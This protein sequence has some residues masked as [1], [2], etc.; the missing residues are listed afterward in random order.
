MKRSYV[1]LGFCIWVMFIAK[2]QIVTTNPAFPIE[3]KAVTLIFDAAQGTA[4]LKGYTGD[5]YAHT[6]VI[7]DQS[8]KESDWRYASDWN[9]NVAKYKMTSLGNNK[10]EL[11]IT[12]DVRSYY[13]VPA[14]EKILKMAFVFRSSDGK[15]EGKD[16]GGKDI[17][18]DIHETGLTVRFDQPSGIA[19]L[20]SGET[21]AMKASASMVADM[22]LFVGNEP[23]ATQSN[24]KEIIAEHTFL[25]AGNFEIRVEATIGGQTET[26]TRTVNVLGE[27]VQAPLPANVRPGINYLS[28]HEATLVLQ[29]PKKKTVHVVGDFNDW[30][31]SPE[32]QLKQDG[33]F[34]WITLSGLE[35]EKEYAFQYVVDG[36]IYIADP[37]A[38]KVLDPWND[39]YIPSTVYPDLKPYP[40]GKAEG[41]VSVLQTGQTPYQWQVTDFKKPDRNQLMVYEM[42]IRD[43]TSEH[44]FNAAKDKLPYLKQLGINAIELMPVNE[45][46][47]NSSW[48]Y[49][50]SFYFAVDKYYGTKNDMRAFVDECHQQG[51]AVIIDLV[52]NHSFGQSPFYLLYR[53]ADGT[54]SADNPWYNQK[55]NIPNAAL[56]WGYDFN[57][58]S[59]YTRALVD[60]VAGFWM[61]EYK[62]DGFRYDFTKG[63][64]N[65]SQDTWANKYDAE[66]IANL[67]RMS[68]EIWKRNSD[69][70]VIIEHL[71][72]GTTE[73]KELGEAGIM[74]WRNMNH[75]YCESAMGW[76]DNSNFSGLYGGTSNMPVNSLMGYMESHDEERTS[77][78]AWKWGIESI[79]GG[80]ASAN[81]TT[82]NNL[83]NRMKQ[84]A[85]N[86]AF[87]FT[88]PGPKMIWQFG[89]LGYDYS[90]NSNSDG[91]VVDDNGAY[92]T[93][94]KPLRWD[95]LENS[96]RKELYNVYSKLMDLRLS[97]PE[98]FS[99]DVIFSWKVSGNT[100]WN[101]GRFI[102]ITSGDKRV[103]VVGNFTAVPGNYSVTFP[104]T[105]TWYDLMDENATLNVTSTTQSVLVPANEF[106]LY[107]NF[108]PALTGI[109][110]T[111]V[112]SASLQVYY[113]SN[114]D[115][116]VIN[117]KAVWVE[118]YSVNGMMVQ[119][120]ENVSSLGLSVLPSGQYVAR[121]K[122]N[123]GEV[124]S[125]KIIK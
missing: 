79:K 106:R 107:T 93:D 47:G 120:Q 75:A 50:P 46:E 30:K 58:Q 110:E 31:L 43:F 66:R 33:E 36:T 74:L 117:T 88:V 24:V 38:D 76:P 54:P 21:L 32:Y 39:S 77:F 97:Y 99:P 86:A 45:F 40:T 96:A 94:P 25:Q 104:Q 56:Q 61:K 65:T 27:T 49:N 10:W 7:T 53:E 90:I 59:T 82:D 23:I 111:V 100:N 29:A 108:K 2:A 113:D 83:E 18:V 115:E 69:A 22:K 19:T 55:S 70:Y 41:I 67:K 84:L 11:N 78:K 44:S 16:T 119:R 92:R 1:L 102:T 48:G 89:E 14:G 118:I 125:C 91:T 63:F 123:K 112:D 28:I 34:F 121:I 64:S 68:S 81:P 20:N 62:V 51:I 35:R 26:A 71:T 80:E 122:G 15:K 101:N 6:G 109:E 72:E 12:P 37:Y 103:V 114:L 52:L 17:F 8:E 57:H 87:F 85:T 73:E 3:G 60:S 124:E 95:Y 98:L 9:V 105:G 42:H 13:G 5:V 4:G 116:L